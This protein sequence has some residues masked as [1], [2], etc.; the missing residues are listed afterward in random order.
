LGTVAELR[1]PLLP[2]LLLGELLLLLLPQPATT[3]AATTA[4]S[5]ATQIREFRISISSSGNVRRIGNL[6]ARADEP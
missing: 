3:S 5:A 6:G 2:L 1:P 4:M